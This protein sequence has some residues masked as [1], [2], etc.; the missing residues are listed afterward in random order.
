M[1][2][3][4]RCILG[5]VAISWIGGL[6]SLALYLGNNGVILAGAMTGI[7]VIVAGLAGYELGL[8]KS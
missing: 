8:K 7:G 4:Y 2:D 3:R 6:A 5:S 1:L